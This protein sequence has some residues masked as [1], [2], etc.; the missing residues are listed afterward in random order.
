MIKKA[1][2][3]GAPPQYRMV[4]DYRHLNT[5]LKARFY[6]L[7]D[8]DH[9]LR[10]IA[11]AKPKYFSTLDLFS[12]FYQQRLSPESSVFTAFSSSFD[13]FEF[14][15]VPL[16][17]RTSPTSFMAALSRLVHSQL[18]QNAS[19]YIDDLLI[20]HQSF[21]DHYNHLQAVFAKF[22]SAN[23][24]LNASK[25]HFAQ[26]GL[27]YLGFRLTSE[28]LKISEKR[29]AGLTTY[30][31]PR[32][33]RESRRLIGLYSYFRRFIVG[34]AE[35]TARMRFLLR[36]DVK[37]VWTAELEND[38]QTLKNIVMEKATLIFP[39]PSK[40]FTIWVDASSRA[41]GY[42]L[43]QE[44]E[45][46]SHKFV[47]FSGRATREYESRYSATHLEM[48]ALVQAIQ[49]FHPFIAHS[50]FIVKSDHISLSVLKNLKSA[51]NSRLI[52]YS[53]LLQQYDFEI[54]HVKGSQNN[55]SDA[56]SRREYEPEEGGNTAP[57]LLDIHPHDVLNVI[58]ADTADYLN[59]IDV[60]DLIAD[61][62]SDASTDKR[63]G[64]DKPEV[65]MR[66]A[67]HVQIVD[68]KTADAS[69]NAIN[70]VDAT[71]P[72]EA[73]IDDNVLKTWHKINVDIGPAIDLTTQSDCELFKEIIDCLQHDIWPSVSACRATE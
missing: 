39:D 1:R 6:P 49:V 13:H 23:L 73:L 41:F 33:Q 7:N 52:R 20:F 51:T 50:K 40:Q 58:Q 47:S 59:A 4:V 34:F 62:A 38:L 31:S 25:C 11:E 24:R 26:E 36:T 54:Q 5:H 19:L 55:L 37:F 22:K 61:Y 12:S 14:K 72:D 56:L 9:S 21:E 35:I 2:P 42:A 63:W 16:G 65:T 71:D 60:E 64:E 3:V 17:L 48:A 45:D 32:N 18:G 29:F 46:K 28:G 69:P 70:A 30:P 27:D 57:P 10:K 8:L 53:L 66:N 68:S 67:I 15:R 44:Q 43:S